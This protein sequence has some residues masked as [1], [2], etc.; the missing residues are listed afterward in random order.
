MPSKQQAPKSKS[1]FQVMAEVRRKLKHESD[2]WKPKRFLDLGD[3]ELNGVFGN[4]DIGLPYG[5]IVEVSGEPSVGKSVL[6]LDLLAAA[7]ADGAIGIWVD[8]ENSWDDDWSANR[9]VNIDDLNLISPIVGTFGVKKGPNRRLIT[10]QEMLTEAET[11]MSLLHQRFPDQPLFSVVDSVAALLMEEEAEAGI[12]GQ[13]MRSKLALPTMMSS[14]LRRWIG[15]MQ[16]YNAT[17]ILINQLRVNPTTM[18]GD[19]FYT[20]GGKAI[21]FYSHVRVRV[22][23][24]GKGRLL[25]GGKAIGIKGI[26]TNVKNKAGGV[27]GDK[28]G[29]K[30][31]YD[32]RSTFLPA[33]EVKEE[34]E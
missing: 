31:Y 2:G 18:F 23:R 17:T 29:Y 8:A 24:P 34:T 9:G 20:P 14:L 19:P 33:S 26:M 28:C 15:L 11:T 13:N 30:I 10:A 25:K 27:E 32:G 1:K 5:K 7:Q 6:A 12:D 3:P 22:R 16:V 21:Q 4:R